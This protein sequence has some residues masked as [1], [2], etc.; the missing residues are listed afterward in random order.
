MAD[1][2]RRVAENVFADKRKHERKITK[3]LKLE[4]EH[5]AA[6]VKNMQLLRLLRLSREQAKTSD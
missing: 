5:H 4:Q 3:A 2:D 1:R 6:A